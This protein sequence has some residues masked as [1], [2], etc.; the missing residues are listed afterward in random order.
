LNPLIDIEKA[1]TGN[2][3]R[4]GLTGIKQACGAN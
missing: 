4:H 1:E 2:G 3:R